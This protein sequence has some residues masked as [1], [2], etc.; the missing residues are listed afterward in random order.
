MFILSN[1]YQIRDVNSSVFTEQFDARE[2]ITHF[3]VAGG[4]RA[5]S[6]GTEVFALT[7]RGSKKIADVRAQVTCLAGH[8]ELLC[9]GTRSGEVHIF[10]EHRVAIRQFGNHSG[11][12][13]DVVITPANKTITAGRDGSVNVYDL[14]E[15]SLLHSIRLPTGYARRLLVSGGLL[16]CFSRNI[17][18]YDAS[19]YALIR[20]IEFGEPIEHAVQLSESCVCLTSRNSGVLLNTETFEVGEPAVLHAKQITGAAVHEGKLYTVSGD[21]HLK[22]FT[23]ELKC[24][25]DINLNTRLVALA[26]DRTPVVAAADGRVFGIEEA[27]SVDEQRKQRRARAKYVEEAEYEVVQSSKRQLSEIDMMLR[28]F[29]YKGAVRT[30]IRNGDVAKTYA[31]MKFVSEKREAMRVATDADEE[32][33]KDLLQLCLEVM[34]IHEFTPLVVELLTILTS[35]YYDEIVNNDGVRALVG[36]IGDELD[37]IVAFEEAYLK[38]MAFVESFTHE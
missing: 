22:T 5:Y 4:V 3:A 20:E 23:A 1:S 18:V 29:E 9:A 37:R 21:G 36:S 35:R 26:M 11:E 15:G 10:S 17:L 14:A 8:A 25:T 13:T 24:I 16:L 7:K 27:K 30:C 31:V 33:L 12:I 6:V 38:A 28:N 2:P 34:K 32:F 19:S